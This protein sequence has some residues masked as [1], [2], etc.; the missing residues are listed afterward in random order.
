VSRNHYVA[1]VVAQT[2]NELDFV[3]ERVGRT[4]IFYGQLRARCVD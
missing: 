4:P 3:I 1:G 2:G